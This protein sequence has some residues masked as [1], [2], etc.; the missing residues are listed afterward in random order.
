L[1]QNNRIF[2]TKHHFKKL[3]PTVNPP[4][5]AS[6]PRWLDKAELILAEVILTQMGPFK[7]KIKNKKRILPNLGVLNDFFSRK[8]EIF[9]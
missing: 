4:T 8:T 7:M 3:L 1:D 5:T 2:V 6:F 9:E